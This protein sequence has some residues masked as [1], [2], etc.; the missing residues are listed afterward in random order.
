MQI[1]AGSFLE[2]LQ[3][4]HTEGLPIIL[5]WQTDWIFAQMVIRQGR[6]LQISVTWASVMNRQM[7]DFMSAMAPVEIYITVKQTW[8]LRIIA[9]L[10]FNSLLLLVPQAGFYPGMG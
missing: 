9:I 6:S 8:F 1:P 5:K 10:I 4:P 2:M 7:H 3:T